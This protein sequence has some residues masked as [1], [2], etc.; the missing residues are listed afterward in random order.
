MATSGDNK[1]V[2]ESTIND[3]VNVGKVGT[4]SEQS[5]TINDP[6]KVTIT[7]VQADKDDKTQAQSSSSS[8][9]LLYTSPSPRD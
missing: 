1:N 7:V 6:V 8:A 3:L 4:S 5:V 9:C 2:N